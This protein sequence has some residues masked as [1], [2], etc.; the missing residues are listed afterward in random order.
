M[1]VKY[2][3][4]NRLES[5]CFTLC[6]PGSIYENGALTNVVGAL[7]D[8]EAEEIVFNFNATSELNMRVT[9]V[10]R[11][12]DQDNHY[13]N[14]I[15]R[16]IQNRRLVFVD[17][18]GYFMVTGIEDGCSDGQQYKDISAKSID[19][20]ISQKMIPYIADGTYRFRTDES[21]ENKG[22]LESIVEVLPLW[23][24]EYV[25]NAVATRWRTFEDVDTSLDCLSFML[26]NLQDAF[27]C[28]FI[29]DNIHRTISVYDQANYVRKTSIH[30]TKDDLINSLS[31]SENAD[32]IYTALSVLGND[33]VTI[34]AVNPIGT[35]TIYDFSYYI[36][37]MSDSLGA[38]VKTWQ[39]AVYGATESYYN[40]NLQYYEKLSEA[41]DVELE[42]ERL[43]TQITMY[44]RCRENIVAES[45]TALTESYNAVIVE[46]GGTPITIHEEIANTLAHIDELIAQSK[47]EKSDQ[48]SALTDI[49]AVLEEK[50][51]SIDAISG[52]F[53]L[54]SYFTENEYA[55][56]CHYIFEGKY[57]DEYVTITDSMTYNDKFE[58]MKTLYDRARNR[59]NIAS[60][61]TQEFSV[62]VES[63]IFSK[64]FEAWGEQLETGC[65]INV[66]LDTNDVAELFLSTIT[67][68]YE[69][70][71]LSLTFGNRFNKFDPKSLYN[72]VL[73]QIS[74]SAN[75][76]NSIK[77]LLQPIKNGELN[78]VQTAMQT[79]RNLTMGAAL[80]ASNER[81][82]ID[83][84]GYTGRQILPDGT[85]DPCQVKITSNSIV[86]TDDGWQTC[87]TA[88]GKILLGDGTYTYGLNAESV[89]A[90]D[91]I[92][93]GS[94]TTYIEA[95]MEPGEEEAQAILMHDVE[96]ELIPD[97]RLHL[98]DFSGD[99][100]VDSLDAGI[101]LRAA[102]G[103]ESLADWPGAQLS[104][105]MMR[106]NMRDP[107]NFI[108]IEGTNMWGRTVTRRFGANLSA[109]I[110][111]FIS[112]IY[113]VGSIYLSGENASVSPEEI[114]G[115]VWNE[116]IDTGLNGV[117]TWKRIA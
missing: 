33:N 49:K 62:D 53:A 100:V 111:P 75:T 71:S 60:T 28:I 3:R 102:R 76:L 104:T 10:I 39:D 90:R 116:M 80:A 99:G 95:F 115:G 89:F 8:H 93:T 92:M 5:P 27:E 85:F 13:A 43:D 20:E 22:I 57:S 18:I 58:Q 31:V 74:K 42:I 86:F 23:T 14:S 81:V 65:L 84:S 88:L 19:I 117:K 64:E 25:D 63:F 96:L 98:Y 101:A 82:V 4:L 7:I 45:S 78:D 108:V 30:I 41:S 59:L 87:E 47:S 35:N 67:I 94:F 61:P 52:G 56:L 48:E 34:S 68:N 2:N 6:N 113:P 36:D 12:N 40:L 97:E 77:D 32:D 44:S 110:H 24:I 105:I 107:E 26:E 106:I 50:K 69:E 55:E 114:F 29:F 103:R 109:D 38:K 11:D 46:N 70:L 16:A 79:S 1:I 83:G 54:Q 91:I 112:A 37:W 72:D 15:Y 73:G 66:E 9:R 17:D 21:G 51:G